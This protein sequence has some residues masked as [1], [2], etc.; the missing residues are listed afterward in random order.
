MSSP[1]NET[2]FLLPTIFTYLLPC[3]LFFLSA[4][5]STIQAKTDREFHS[6]PF[7]FHFIFCFEKESSTFYPV[8][9]LQQQQKCALTAEDEKQNP[10]VCFY[11]FFI[12]R[13][14]ELRCKP[15]GTFFS[16]SNLGFLNA[17]R[18]HFP[19]SEK[20]DQQ[21]CPLFIGQ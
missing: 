8:Q 6:S 5:C 9:S 17:K 11:L 15:T 12:F 18:K 3:V 2:D 4:A 7:L 14:L 10:L 21:Q 1:K 20:N 19:N 16:S 13:N